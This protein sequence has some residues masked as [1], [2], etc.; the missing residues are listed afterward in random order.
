M[1]NLGQDSSKKCFRPKAGL[2]LRRS[3]DWSSPSLFAAIGFVLGWK[4]G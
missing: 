3:D 4:G 1:G 2:Y